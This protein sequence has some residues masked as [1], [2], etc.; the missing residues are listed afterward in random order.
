MRLNYALPEPPGFSTSATVGISDECVFRHMHTRFLTLAVTTALSSNPCL[1]RQQKSV[2]HDPAFF[3][4]HF[5]C[6]WDTQF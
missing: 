5:R 6:D 4:R 2:I 1:F 3:Q